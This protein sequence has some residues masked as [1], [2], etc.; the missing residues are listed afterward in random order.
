[1]FGQSGAARIQIPTLIAGGGYDFITP[2][3]P[4]Q[5]D[6]FSWLT[7]PEKYFLLVDQKAHGA[8]STRFLMQ[9][10]YSLEEDLDL[11][12]TQAWLRSNYKALLVAFVQTYV[13]DREEYRPYLEASY[14]NYISQPPFAMH[15][16]HDLSEP[17]SVEKN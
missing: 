11:E 10:F 16:V 9:F 8:E 2:I 6:T 1:L 14:A 7:T 5:A 3:L 12:L 4:E 13:S 17:L 15:M